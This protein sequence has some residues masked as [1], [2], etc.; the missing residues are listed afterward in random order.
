MICNRCGSLLPAQAAT[1]P[2]CNNPSPRV[3]VGPIEINKIAEARAQGFTGRA[4]VLD[5][6]LP[7]AYQGQA[8]FFLLTGEPGSGKTALAAWLAGAGP[9]PVDPAER[10]RLGQARGLWDAAHFCIAPDH[11]GSLDPVNF[12]RQ[13]AQKLSARF[14]DYVNGVVLT[15]EERVRINQVV[16]ENRGTVV[17]MQIQAQVVNLV[18]NPSN[19]LDT[20]NRVVRQPLSFLAQRYPGVRVF[21]LVDALD[22][23]LAVP[24]PNIVSLLAGSGDLPEGVRF[25]LTSRNDQRVWEQFP[26]SER[27][28]LSDPQH[29]TANEADLRAYVRRRLGE[30]QAPAALESDILAGAEGNFLYTQFV[31]DELKSGQRQAGGPNKLPSGLFGLYREYLFRLVPEM[32]SSGQ[33]RRWTSE[34]QPL[35]GSV[36]VA[37]PAAPR[38][39]LPGWSGLGGKTGSRLVDI[40]QLTEEIPGELGGVQLYHRSMADFLDT[41]DYEENR[42][43]VGNYFHTPAFEQHGRIIRYY[44]KAF[45]QAWNECDEYG[46]YRLGGHLCARVAL[47]PDPAK[48]RQAVKVLYEHTLD[49]SFRRAQIETIGDVQAALDDLGMVVRIALQRQEWLRAL[50]FAGIY[51]QTLRSG[52]IPEGI[53][54]AVDQGNFARARRRAAYFGISPRPRGRWAEV[55]Q[56]YL[57]WEAAEQGRA[58][59]VGNLLESA[60]RLPPLWSSPMADA[61]RARTARSLACRTPGRTAQEWLTAIVT[62]DGADALLAQ[63]AEAQPPDPLK[64]DDLVAEMNRWLDGYQALIEDQTQDLEA[65]MMYSLD[66]NLEGFAGPLRDRLL[67]LAADPAGQQGIRRALD[68]LR[69]NAYARYRDIGLAAAGAACLAVPDP[70]FVRGCL[71][72]ILTTALRQETLVFALDL[73]A[74]LETEATRRNLPAATPG[75]AMLR[76]YQAGAMGSADLWGSAL[77]AHSAAA[78]ALFWQ[79]RS[80]EAWQE[81]FHASA[82]QEGFAG[83]LSVGMLSLAVRCHEFGEAARAGQPDWGDKQYAT[84]RSLAGIKAERV[85]DPGFRQERLDLVARFGQWAADPAPDYQTA[86]SRL[87][88][89]PDPDVRRVWKDLASARWAAPA[90]RDEGSLTALLPLLLHDGTTLDAVLG[91]LVGPHVQAFSDADLVEAIRLCAAYFLGDRPWDVAAPSQEYA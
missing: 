51:R 14:P 60:E 85:R 40:A 81:L 18:V 4:W 30:M 6:V 50:Q 55:L 87:S 1:C 82:Q 41:P 15:D 67:P 90:V 68:M 56:L 75:L 69:N 2:A 12:A 73:P 88:E 89:M 3:D 76:E 33:G 61:L 54:E 53:F 19:P 44:Q 39:L 83:L 46:L 57:A 71:R 45:Q 58:D 42:V 37:T 91:R 49:D 5:H 65:P 72:Q 47:A 63:Y 59:E 13:L 78:A 17:G 27:L 84:L 29:A 31:L 36:S 20:Y 43:T 10:Q 52:R 26:A 21:I 24:M 79:G 64:R 34:Y 22:E 28:D 48:R 23:A 74:H 86:Q 77:C 35:L 25:L 80:D 62:N 11:G 70:Q 8:R 32:R 16:H 66:V 9:D 7:W 38:R